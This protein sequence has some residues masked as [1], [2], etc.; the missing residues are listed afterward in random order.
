MTSAN[1]LRAYKQQFTKA[2]NNTEKDNWVESDLHVVRDWVADNILQA[3]TETLIKVN[4]PKSIP[5]KNFGG[6]VRP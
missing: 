2:L 1:D 6:H 3:Q 5:V 4:M